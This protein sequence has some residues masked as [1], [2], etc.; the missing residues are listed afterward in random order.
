MEVTDNIDMAVVYTAHSLYDFFIFHRQTLIVLF[1]VRYL[2]GMW[3]NLV[4]FANNRC[5][6]LVYQDHLHT[7]GKKLAPLVYKLDDISRALTIQ[8]TVE[9][10]DIF[11]TIT[12]MD[13]DRQMYPTIDLATIRTLFEGN[14]GNVPQFFIGHNTIPEF[15]R[16]LVEGP[17]A[18]SIRTALLTS[19][20]AS[21]QESQ[22]TNG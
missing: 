14:P 16:M 6:D 11:R 22:R 17:E 3:S 19:F 5:T 1:L 20:H 21:Y 10:N 18:A 4:V 7:Y 8:G 2:P 12:T 9:P 13:I 15:F